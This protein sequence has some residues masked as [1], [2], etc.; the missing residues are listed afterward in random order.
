MTCTQEVM[1]KRNGEK[2]I[3]IKMKEYADSRFVD[4]ENPP[5]LSALKLHEV[6][7]KLA[8]DKVGED[9]WHQTTLT[10]IQAFHLVRHYDTKL[11]RKT[12]ME[13][14]KV[15]L[16]F[17]NDD[18]GIVA[19]LVDVAHIS[20]RKINGSVSVRW[21][22]GAGFCAVLQHSRYWAIVDYAT[23]MAM[24]S[25]YALRLYEI[26]ALR[27][28]L[29]H[30]KTET[31]SIEDLRGRLGVKAGKLKLF[32]D[33]SKVALQ[34]AIAEINRLAAFTLSF[35][36]VREGRAFTAVKLSWHKKPLG[37]LSLLDGGMGESKT[38][39][40]ALTPF[41]ADGGIGFSGWGEI[42]RQNLPFP[43]RDVDQVADEFRR[44]C[45]G[46]GLALTAK[47]IDRAFKGFCKK[48]KPVN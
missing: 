29:S 27:I 31:F 41:P 5:S 37:Q 45:A 1:K 35:E 13:L 40:A 3:S 24:S 17:E 2:E 7:M 11:L 38:K 8:G 20:L 21:K 44:W 4:L 30:K 47:G 39:K 33:F 23:I 42:A 48:V 18:D 10:Q 36:P 6:L 28:N 19:G 32:A 15:S 22:F 25:R 26:M 43:Q 46:R 16:E 14:R 12:F 9:C 34:P